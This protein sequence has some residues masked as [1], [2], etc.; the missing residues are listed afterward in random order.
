MDAKL[1]LNLHNKLFKLFYFLNHL[2]TQI[3][4]CVN[5]YIIVTCSENFYYCCKRAVVRAHPTA[6]EQLN[7]NPKT[8]TTTTTNKLLIIFVLKFFAVSL[9]H[10]KRFTLFCE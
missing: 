7:E 6:G 2:I 5:Y 4:V 3:F 8:T 1:D 10:T 9:W